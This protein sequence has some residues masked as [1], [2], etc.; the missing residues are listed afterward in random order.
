MGRGERW[1]SAVATAAGLEL[2]LERGCDLVCGW[3]VGLWEDPEEGPV[4]RRVSA[5][6][7]A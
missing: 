5:G 3:G 4:G 7:V 1:E 2:D 6:L